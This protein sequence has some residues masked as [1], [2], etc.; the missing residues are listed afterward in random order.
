MDVYP[1]NTKE[2]SIVL[3]HLKDQMLDSE[4]AIKRLALDGGY[5]VGAVHRGLELLGIEGYIPSIPYSNGPEK[6]GFTYQMEN[7][8]F[9]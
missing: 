2:S 8:C 7:D 5:D 3:K 4:F 9:I 1:A 6:H